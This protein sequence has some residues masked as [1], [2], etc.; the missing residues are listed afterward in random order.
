MRKPQ[1][2]YFDSDTVSC[3]ANLS[4]LTGRERDSIRGLRSSE[5]LKK[6]PVGRRLLYFIMAEKLYFEPRIQLP[7]LKSVLA[8]RPK[9]T[10]RRILAQ[11]GAF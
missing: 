4:S 11:Q 10:N 3:V 8:V 6:S 1:L 9:Q 2:W 7:D 5:A